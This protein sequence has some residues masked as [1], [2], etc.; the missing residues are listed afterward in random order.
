ML[1]DSMFMDLIDTELQQW[2]VN[3]NDLD[4]TA[5]DALKL[6]LESGPT[7]MTIGLS[8]WKSG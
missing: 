1:P 8:A 5:A 7:K 6:L 4:K 3:S 2:I